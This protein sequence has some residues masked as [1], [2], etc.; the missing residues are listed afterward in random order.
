MLRDG[1]GLDM[2]YLGI[3]RKRIIKRG[4]EDGVTGDVVRSRE[5]QISP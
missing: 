4:W 5:K 2:A 1:V 3:C